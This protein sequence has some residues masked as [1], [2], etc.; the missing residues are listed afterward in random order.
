MS[1]LSPHQV[2]S[3]NEMIRRVL[4]Y[5]SDHDLAIEADR[6]AVLDHLCSDF[7]TWLRLNRSEV[8]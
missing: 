5:R 8:T 3:L 7:Q 2:A 6:D 4:E 1:E